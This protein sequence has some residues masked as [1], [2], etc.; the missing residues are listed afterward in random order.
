M[1]PR[2]QTGFCQLPSLV[3]SLGLVLG[4]TGTTALGAQPSEPTDPLQ[5]AETGTSSEVQPDHPQLGAP[6][7]TTPAMRPRIQQIPLGVN[8]LLAHHDSLRWIG[9]QGFEGLDFTA[10][11]LDGLVVDETLTRF[12]QTFSTAFKQ[13]WQAPEGAQRYTITIQEKMTPG[14]GT[15]VDVHVNQEVVYQTR[16]TPRTEATEHAAQQAAAHVQRHLTTRYQPRTF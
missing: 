9:D 1:S 11:E 15:Q 13:V 4:A 5:A 7:P 2:S 6:V 16:L 3:L 10:L 14:R 8:A 12:G